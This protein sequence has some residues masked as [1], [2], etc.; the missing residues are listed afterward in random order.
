MEARVGQNM[1]SW[2]WSV[3]E[4][5]VSSS[6]IHIREGRPVGPSLVGGGGG[7]RGGGGQA[8]G[9]GSPFSPELGFFHQNVSVLYFMR[10]LL[11]L[12]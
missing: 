11:S 6:D 9:C 7:G 10:T 8:F 4:W 2:P 12:E 5:P 3:P 1:V